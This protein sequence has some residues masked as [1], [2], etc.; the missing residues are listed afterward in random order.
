MN[1]YSFI[2]NNGKT[3]HFEKNENEY[4]DYVSKKF[5]HIAVNHLTFYL[6]VMVDVMEVYNVES[7]EVYKLIIN[8]SDN[9][10]SE[11]EEQFM[12]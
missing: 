12:F 10:Y 7:D 8:E 3:H 9:I 4:I 11:S 5:K 6:I 1:I 2:D